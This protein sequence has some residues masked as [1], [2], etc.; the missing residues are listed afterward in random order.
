VERK[1]PDNFAL[2]NPRAHLNGQE[3]FL[4]CQLQQTQISPLF[5]SGD[6]IWPGI[7]MIVSPLHAS[8]LKGTVAMCVPGVDLWLKD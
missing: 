7:R 6:S 3:R 2:F 4:S 1:I 8:G 5:A